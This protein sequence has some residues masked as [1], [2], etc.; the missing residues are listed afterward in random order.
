MLISSSAFNPLHFPIPAAQHLP[1][2]ERQ[3]RRCSVRPVAQRARRRVFVPCG[4]PGGHEAKLEMSKY[5]VYVHMYV[6]YIYIY[7]CLF[8]D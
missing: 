2:H 8:T 3:L 4:R 1:L 5:Y 6:Y 7:T